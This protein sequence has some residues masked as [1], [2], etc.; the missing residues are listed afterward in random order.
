[1]LL[2]NRRGQHLPVATACGGLEYMFIEHLDPHGGAPPCRPS[3][4]ESPEKDLILATLK[5]VLLVFRCR[6]QP[7]MQ[8]QL[9]DDLQWISENSEKVMGFVW[10][11]QHLGI[12]ADK[13]QAH[14][15]GLVN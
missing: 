10:S 12:N 7:E 3:A 14:L 4:P 2:S 8:R 9:A 5:D 13:L 6:H 1:M 15:L 11:C